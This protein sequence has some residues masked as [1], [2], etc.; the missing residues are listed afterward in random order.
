MPSALRQL[1]AVTHTSCQGQWTQLGGRRVYEISAPFALST[2][3]IRPLVTGCNPNILPAST[4]CTSSNVG[5]GKCWSDNSQ[6]GNGTKVILNN[7]D[8]QSN[9]QSWHAFSGEGGSGFS[10]VVDNAGQC[11]NDPNGSTTAGT[12]QQ[13]WN[14]FPTTVEDYGVADV[15]PGGSQILLAVDGADPTSSSN[16]CLTDNANSNSGAPLV[17]ASCNGSSNQRWVWPGIAN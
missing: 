8:P 11:L 7:C 15:G 17:I 10:W 2:R 16:A 6:A 13:I 14:C 12:Q 9:G 4:Y 5:G 1:C 3:G